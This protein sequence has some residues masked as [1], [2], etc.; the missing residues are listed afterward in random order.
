MTQQQM[1]LNLPVRSAQ[2]RD[3]FFVTSSNELALRKID[4]WG[5]WANSKLVLIGPEGSGKSHLVAVWA[6]LAGATVVSAD[7]IDE[8]LSGHVAVEDADRIA[9]NSEREEALFHLHNRLA[10]DGHSLLLTG[11]DAPDLWGIRLPDLKSRI[12]AADI[13]RLDQP[14]D[15]LLAALLVKLFS[16]RQLNVSP[17]VITYLTTRIDRSYAEAERIVAR[18]DEA[19][20]R[21]RKPIS[22]RFAG[23]VLKD[24][25]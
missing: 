5:N 18:L 13:G 10:S 22:V 3:E 7:A 8:P 21:A 9:G 1:L 12:L 20:M 25:A 24:G 16:D 11:R 19:S 17:D 4:D 2:G 6:E 15:A 14:D 23:S